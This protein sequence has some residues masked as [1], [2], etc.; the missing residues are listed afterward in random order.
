MNN[1]ALKIT[2]TVF[3][4]AVIIINA[5]ANIIPIG[6]GKTGEVS[7]KYPNLFTPAPLTFAIWGVIYLLMAL[8][9]LYQWG[10][11]GSKQTSEKDVEIIGAWFAVSCAMNIGWIFS[12]HF[13]KIPLSLGFMLGLLVSLAVIGRKISRTKRS[14]FTY[15][16]MDAGF[17]IYLGWIIAATIAN[18]SVFLVSVGWNGFGISPVVWTCVILIAGALIGSLPAL[19][20]EKWLSALAVI[21]AY[22][23][24]LVRQIGVNGLA[25]RYPVIITFAIAGIVIITAA[26]T[27]K[28]YHTNIKEITN[29]TKPEITG[30]LYEKYNNI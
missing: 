16:A 6:I 17:D 12:W 10:L 29:R 9:I 27:I 20:C 15:I 25:G 30:G 2:N 24:I 21:W 5:L 3:F 1:K 22:A 11:I 26:I 28:V 18:V 14:G 7:E 4:A 19:I 8:F 23:G 13:N